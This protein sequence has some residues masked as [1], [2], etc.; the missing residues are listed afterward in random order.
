MWVKSH[1]L[2]TGTWHRFL[3][4]CAHNCMKWM[5]EK[6]YVRVEKADYNGSRSVRMLKLTSALYIIQALNKYSGKSSRNVN[7][8]DGTL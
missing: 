6:A 5:E 2:K 3:D 1:I 7:T 8:I 4:E